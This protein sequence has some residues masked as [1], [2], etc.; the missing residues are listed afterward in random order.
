MSLLEHMPPIP[1][2]SV[3][4]RVNGGCVCVSVC[5]ETRSSGVSPG[6]FGIPVLVQEKPQEQ[7]DQSVES[8]DFY[9]VARLPRLPL[10]FSS[11]FLIELEKVLLPAPVRGR[12]AVVCPVKGA[13]RLCSPVV[14]LTTMYVLGQLTSVS[15]F[16][17]GC[18]CLFKCCC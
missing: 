2:K 7:P 8:Q 13:A 12:S 5:Q 17:L 11:Y 9:F 18:L 4:A 14:T 3:Y 10:F 1:V 16:A 6:L 15:Q